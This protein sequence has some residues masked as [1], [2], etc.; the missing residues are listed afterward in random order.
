MNLQKQQHFDDVKDT[1][2]VFQGLLEVIALT[3]MYYFMWKLFYRNTG[4]FPYYGMGKFILAGVY[5]ALLIVVFYL[6]DSFQY[7]HMKL[8]DIIISQWISVII[9]DIITYFQL[10]LMAN[11]MLNPLGMISILGLSFGISA[12][13]CYIFTAIYHS[14][15]VPKNM[16]MIYGN[17]NAVSLKFKMDTRE[18]KY[19]VTINGLSQIQ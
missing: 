7:G 5:F 1:I 10:C 6:C 19:K 8:T 11:H 12:L 3:V 16:V 4:T 15:N 17:E 13:C 2:K 9:I 18:D 14:N